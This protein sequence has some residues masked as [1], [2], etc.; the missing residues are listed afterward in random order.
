MLHITCHDP[1][2]SSHVS[3]QIQH[4][5]SVHQSG[6]FKPTLHTMVAL[7]E[8]INR[9]DA[10]LSSPT[11]ST[12]V[13]SAASR[14]QLTPLLT[15]ALKKV[16]DAIE[17]HIQM[18]LAPSAAPSTSKD[19]TTAAQPPDAL[20]TSAK[21]T[22]YRV[23][24]STTGMSPQAPAFGIVGGTRGNIRGPQCSVM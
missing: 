5:H 10:V 1:P 4:P 11:S 7:S 17:G 15:T 13:T 9:L 23:K 16:H 20:S 22:V 19:M 12:S 21:T 2:C 8:S 6:H 24:S 3:L 18:A 14:S